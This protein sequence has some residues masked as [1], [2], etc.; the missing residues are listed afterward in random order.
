MKKKKPSPSDLSWT[1]WNI[2]APRVPAPKAGGRPPTDT[3]RQILNGILFVVRTGCI[4]RAIPH[5]VPAWGI[6]YHCVRQWR[7]DGTWQ[8]IHDVL[9]DQ[10]RHRAG[11]RPEPHA[12]ISD[13]QRVKTPARG[14]VPGYDAGKR[15]LGRKR[16]LLVDTHGLVLAVLVQAANL[17]DRVSAKLLFAKV[18][19]QFRHITYVYADGGYA[20]T[21]I[22]WGQ[23][24]LGWVLT[25]VLRSDTQ[26]GF[27]V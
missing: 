7:C 26:A 25:L 15:V 20:G 21:L 11:R 5:D 19:G 24:T 6:W 17:Q 10:C 14:G 9:G 4:W 18:Q 2:L 1:Q 22:Q 27:Q 3:R 16:H 23:Q 12:A 13:S 8:R